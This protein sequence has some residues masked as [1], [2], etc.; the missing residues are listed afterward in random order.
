VTIKKKTL[1][2]FGRIENELQI[3]AVDKRILDL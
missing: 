3:W 2:P 1:K